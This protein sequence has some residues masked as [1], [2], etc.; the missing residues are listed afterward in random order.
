MKPLTGILLGVGAL[1]AAIAGAVWYE[2]KKAA[3]ATPSSPVLNGQVSVNADENYTATASFP[4]N[5]TA[6]TVQTAQAAL[7]ASV[8][9]VTGVSQTTQGSTATTQLTFTG[10]S[11]GTITTGMLA[12]AMGAPA[13]TAVSVI[14]TSTAIA[15]AGGSSSFGNSTPKQ[16]SAN[17]S[18]TGTTLAMNVGDGL[19]VSLLQ[20]SGGAWAF[21]QS[22]DTLQLDGS[23]TTAADPSSAGGTDTV[24]SYSAVDSGQTILTATSGNQSWKL[25]VNVS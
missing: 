9:T 16:L 12:A 13:G 23:P 11:N 7:P 24:Q 17:Y 15:T 25:T 10:A 8:V 3:A 18:S 20:G 2:E 21:S 5:M 19:K 14:D 1:G 6:V 4:A 22:G